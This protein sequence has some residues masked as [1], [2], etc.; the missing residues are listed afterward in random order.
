MQIYWDTTT[1]KSSVVNTEKLLSK[2]TITRDIFDIK[3]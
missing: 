1:K 2:Y 3:T